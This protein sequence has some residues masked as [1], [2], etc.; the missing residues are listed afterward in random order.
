MVTILISAAEARRLLE[1]STYIRKAFISMWVLKG[2]ALHRV[3]RIFETLGL[4]EEIRYVKWLDNNGMLSVPN[5]SSMIFKK[6][7]LS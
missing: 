7:D 1:G 4:L 6:L 3:R 5:A 2:A